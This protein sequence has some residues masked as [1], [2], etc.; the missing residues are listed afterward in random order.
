M[1]TKLETGGK[2]GLVP[3]MPS[4]LVL[5]ETV[6]LEKFVDDAKEIDSDGG[7]GF[8][9]HEIN[10]FDKIVAGIWPDEEQKYHNLSVSS[11]DDHHNHDHKE[12]E[13]AS[14]SKK[15]SMSKPIVMDDD[16]NGQDLKMD[17]KQLLTEWSIKPGIIDDVIKKMKEEGCEDPKHWIDFYDDQQY[18]I[19][20]IGMERIQA[21]K[22]EREY[23]EWKKI[24]NSNV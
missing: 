15:D 24:K 3:S 1:N 20:T 9:E 17:A 5:T 23:R 16:G 18:L 7:G 22:F 14:Q 8:K 13:D 10:K 21:K 2:I 12:E 19:D 11:Y 4:G 6:M